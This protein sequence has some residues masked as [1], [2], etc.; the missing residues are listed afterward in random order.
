MLGFL[1][2]KEKRA[3]QVPQ[4]PQDVQVYLLLMMISIP[5][6]ILVY[7]ELMVL[8]V[9]LEIV[10]LKDHQDNLVEKAFPAGKG[11]WEGMV[12]QVSLALWVILVSLVFPDPKD[13]KVLQEGKAF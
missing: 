9:G 11:R 6:E 5:L 7:L 13:L 3:T 12:L 10:E 2:L 8:M 4:V 1:V